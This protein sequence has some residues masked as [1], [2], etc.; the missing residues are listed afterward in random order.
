[1][2]ATL[3]GHRRLVLAGLYDL[4]GCA[5]LAGPARFLAR[6]RTTMFL[7]V[8][9]WPASSW[10]GT[11]SVARKALNQI[12][13]RPHCRQGRASCG[14]R[15]TSCRRQR[16]TRRAGERQRIMRAILHD[17]VA[18]SWWALLNSCSSPSPSVPC[19]KSIVK[20]ALDEMRLAVD[21]CS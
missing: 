1:M 19:W 7:F 4:A 5:C 6:H 13:G 11:R 12:A 10:T 14:R 17:G 16:A 9:A 18:P 20:A 3:L 21:R 2:T 8:T 15:L